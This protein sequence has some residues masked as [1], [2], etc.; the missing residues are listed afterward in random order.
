MHRGRQ[1][2]ERRQRPGRARRWRKL[3]QRYPD[4]AFVHGAPDEH[5]G[6][7]YSLW[8]ALPNLTVKSI[9][10]VGQGAINAWRGGD[11]HWY[12]LIEWTTANA[13]TAASDE[14]VNGTCASGHLPSM[15]QG[16][17][18]TRNA[19]GA[20]PAS[21]DFSRLDASSRASDAIGPRLSG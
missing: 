10:E 20:N 21:N 2:P 18:G 16:S 7:L 1:R 14:A 4:I 12:P 19:V 3:A 15:A 17:G 8:Q 11:G 6:Q 9:A 5:L 13:T